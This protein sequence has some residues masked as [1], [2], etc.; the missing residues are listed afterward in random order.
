MRRGETLAG[1]EAAG[2]RRSGSPKPFLAALVLGGVPD[3]RATAALARVAVR[4]MQDRWARAAVLSGIGGREFEILEAMTAQI[5]P[6]SQGVSDFLM[7]LGR[8]FPDVATIRAAGLG[9]TNAPAGRTEMPEANGRF[10]IGAALLLG[11][12]EKNGSR[13]VPDAHF[14]GFP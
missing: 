8:G 14:D 4:D 13:L 6:T 1:G 5:D 10:A 7:V 12:S 9:N 2:G 11:F 3:P